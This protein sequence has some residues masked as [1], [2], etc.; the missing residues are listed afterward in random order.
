MTGRGRGGPGTAKSGRANTIG[1][2]GATFRIPKTTRGRPG[3][4]STDADGFTKVGRDGK[5]AKSAETELESDGL[6]RANRS[7]LRTLWLKEGRCLKCGSENHRVADCPARQSPVIGDDRVPDRPNP[8]TKGKAPNKAK[9]A[10][11]GKGEAEGATPKQ[12][13]PAKGASALPDGTSSQARQRPQGEGVT[14]K[15]ADSRP[16]TGAKRSHD[17]SSSGLTPPSKKNL[18][19]FSYAQASREATELAIVNVDD[20]HI[21]RK[22]F[23]SYEQAVEDAWVACL[24]KG[25]VPFHVEKWGYTKHYATVWVN[26]EESW[27]AIG[28]V[29][30]KCGLH[31]VPKQQLV[32]KRKPACILS[33]FLQGP[34]ARRPRETLERYLKFEKGRRNIPGR[35][36]FYQTV[37]TPHN[38]CILKLVVDETALG[39]LTELDFELCLGT[40]GKVKFLDE[41]AGTKSNSLTRQQRLMTLEKELGELRDLLR[42]KQGQ[43]SE[44]QKQV[45]EE[46]AAMELAE[47]PQETGSNAMETPE[48]AGEDAEEK[49]SSH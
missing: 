3:A 4:A 8:P 20:S 29:A 21:S 12:T 5:P 28:V 31:L 15:A 39:R 25:M 45:E 41:R 23:G 44:L 38:N 17:Q 33:G 40:S 18:T 42:D 37:P 22:D 32:E 6:S 7:A 49:G 35:L 47:P 24:D 11:G 48:T 36:E 26:D 43:R 13:L 2:G 46:L 19:K 34:V 10:A 9:S 27:A 30:D 14:S 16:A 1:A